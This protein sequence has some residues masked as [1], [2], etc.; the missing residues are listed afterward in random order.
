MKVRA[1]EVNPGTA[2]LLSFQYASSHID[3]AVMTIR[4]EAIHQRS[5]C[6]VTQA[7]RV[8]IIILHPEE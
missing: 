6:T 3:G 4:T 1:A 8:I 7:Q 5:W 2:D